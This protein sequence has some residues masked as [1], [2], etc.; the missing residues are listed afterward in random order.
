MQAKPFGNTTRPKWKPRTENNEDWSSYT[1]TSIYEDDQGV[2]HGGKGLGERI[3]IN[4]N[5]SEGQIGD[6]SP[7]KPPLDTTLPILPNPNNNRNKV[8]QKSVRKTTTTTN[9][10][11]PTP[12]DQLLNQL[13]LRFNQILNNHN[14]TPTITTTKNIRKES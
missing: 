8:K 3:V 1:H 4:E 10:T 9:L 14:A 11:Y 7:E 5:A 2:L 13:L 6:A 12:T